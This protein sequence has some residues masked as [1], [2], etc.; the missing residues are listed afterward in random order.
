[1][2]SPGVSAAARPPESSG[3]G[4]PGLVLLV[5]DEPLLLRSLQRIL[6]SEGHRTAL[7]DSGQTVAGRAAVHQPERGSGDE[8]PG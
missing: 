8:L 4:A 1:M 6:V 7:A 5:D 2:A 3:D